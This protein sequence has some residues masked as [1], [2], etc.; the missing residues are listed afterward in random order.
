MLLGPFANAQPGK[1]CNSSVKLLLQVD[2]NEPACLCQSV[3]FFEDVKL[4][5][6]CNMII[7]WNKSNSVKKK[8]NKKK[9][10]GH[11]GPKSLT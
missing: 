1:M 5:R 4:A 8:K 2:F 3:H 10:E 11:D 7:D 9:Q 6:R